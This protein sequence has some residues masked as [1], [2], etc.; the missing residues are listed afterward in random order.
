MA[1]FCKACS[2]EHFGKDFGDH[3]GL[4]HA[5][6]VARGI[7]ANVICEG[8]GFILVDHDGNCISDDCSLKGHAGHGYRGSIEPGW[9]KEEEEL[10]DR[11]AKEKQ[12]D[13]G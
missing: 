12:G 9:T 10:V 6:E 13:S 3:A 11:L 8:C 1:D 5:E 7:G 2:I 4:I